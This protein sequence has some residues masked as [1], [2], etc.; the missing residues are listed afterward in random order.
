MGIKNSRFSRV[1]R[2]KLL[3]AHTLD[4][5]VTAFNRIETRLEQLRQRDMYRRRAVLSSPQ[6]REVEIDGRRLLNF[7]SNDYLGL[8]GDPRIRDALKAG[9]DQ[10]GTGSGAS[11]LICGYTAAHQALE[12]ALADFVGRPSALL[13]TNGYAAN[14]GVINALVGKGDSVFEDRLNHASL[15]DGGWISQARFNWYA[16]SDCHDLDAQLAEGVGSP[17]NQLVVS[18]GTFSMD[19]D[20]CALNDLI[21]VT[22]RH[23][24]WLMI[25]DAHGVGVS[26]NQGCGLVDPATVS[27]TD[28]PVLIATLGKAFGAFGAFI[29]GESTLIEYL[30]QRSRNYIFTT[31]LPAAIAVAALRSVEIVREEEWRR[32]HLHELINRFRQGA[33][34]LGLDLLASATPIQPVIIGAPNRALEFSQ[35]LENSGIL[36]KAIRPPTVAAGTSRLRITLTAAHTTDD[37]DA[38]LTALERARSQVSDES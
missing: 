23:D 28:V 5:L 12:E 13:F 25:D 10:W 22:T 37:I 38:L 11:S 9:A 24:A 18:D 14:M 16:H 8:A 30:I 33:S 2:V 29:A 15:L 4:I 17:T 34:G 21:A 7:C 26:G 31:A 36:V 3:F 1:C 27:T 20:Q 19:G 6:G 35:A 32:T